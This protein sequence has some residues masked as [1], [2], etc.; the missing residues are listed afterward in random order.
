MMTPQWLGIFKGRILT[1]YVIVILKRQP[2]KIRKAQDE[3]KYQGFPCFG[4]GKSQAQQMA[5]AG[6]AY[7]SL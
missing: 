6:A 2:L 1:E 3:N 4:A 7:L 5:H